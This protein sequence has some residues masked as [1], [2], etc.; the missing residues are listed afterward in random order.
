MGALPQTELADRGL[1]KKVISRTGDAREFP[2][3]VIASP[4]NK[5]STQL[6]HRLVAAEQQKQ[7]RL[8]SQ[9]F[10]LNI[11][12]S[13]ISAC[14]LLLMSL[15]LLK[16][17]VGGSTHGNLE[18][19]KQIHVSVYTCGSSSIWSA[20]KA[21]RW[22]ACGLGGM[23]VVDIGCRNPDLWVTRVRNKLCQHSDVMINIFHKESKFPMAEQ[24]T[25]ETTTPIVWTGHL[26]NKTRRFFASAYVQ[27]KSVTL[28]G[29]HDCGVKEE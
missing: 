26:I 21:H 7:Q 25:H 3:R 6:N 24:N 20:N 16:S 23:R 13:P 14:W 8:V 17:L 4:H 9:K 22:P 15:R 18:K 28:I 10:K 27:T 12:F 1:E 2:P 29:P 19:T 11:Q 5:H